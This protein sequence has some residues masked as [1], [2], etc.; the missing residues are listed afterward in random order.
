MQT[1]PRMTRLSDR[2]DKA[3]QEFANSKKWSIS[4]AIAEI[5]ANS[6]EISNYL[7]LEDKNREIA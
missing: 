1:T 2:I 5:L 7:S 6:S 3:L 4:L